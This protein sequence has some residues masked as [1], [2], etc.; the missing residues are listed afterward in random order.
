MCSHLTEGLPVDSQNELKLNDLPD[1]IRLTAAQTI[2]LQ[3]I[4]SQNWIQDGHL[5]V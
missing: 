2:V 3:V 5:S 4:Q 1:L